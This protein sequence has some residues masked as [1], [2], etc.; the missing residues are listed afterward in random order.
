MTQID[1]CHDVIEMIM[2]IDNHADDEYGQKAFWKNVW[3]WNL[4]AHIECKSL[5]NADNIFV[6]KDENDGDDKVIE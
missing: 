1:D 6:A 2:I 4:W 3:P 5:S